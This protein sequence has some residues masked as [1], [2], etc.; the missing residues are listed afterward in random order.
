MR[1]VHAPNAGIN[2]AMP[3]VASLAGVPPMCAFVNAL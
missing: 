3:P 1:D 2:I